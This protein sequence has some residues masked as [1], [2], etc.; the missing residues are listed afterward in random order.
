[1]GWHLKAHMP[2]LS[3]LQRVAMVQTP[4]DETPLVKMVATSEPGSRMQ[5]QLHHHNEI[6]WRLNSKKRTH[7]KRTHGICD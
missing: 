3:I 7:V 1:M 6:S 2:A 5:T 4:M